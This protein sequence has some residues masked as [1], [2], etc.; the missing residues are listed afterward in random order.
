MEKRIEFTQEELQT[1][2]TACIGYGGNLFDMTKQIVNCNKAVNSLNDIARDC[3][4]LAGKITEYMED[5][6]N[7]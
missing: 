5:D 3:Y 6:K 7:A 4:D 1:L 2:Y